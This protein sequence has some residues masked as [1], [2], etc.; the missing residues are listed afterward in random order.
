MRMQALM[1][2][3]MFFFAVCQAVEA[4]GFSAQSANREH[5]SY[6]VSEVAFFA[7]AAK[8]VLDHRFTDTSHPVSDQPGVID[9][10]YVGYPDS[11][12]PPEAFLD[13]GE[14]P[15]AVF[16]PYSQRRI[17][18]SNDNWRIY[19]KRVVSADKVDMWYEQDVPASEYGLWGP[20]MAD[21][22]LAKRQET[23]HVIEWSWILRK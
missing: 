14:H 21:V 2:V 16:L 13:Y 8:A 9:T 15:Q 18:G 5:R 10:F 4:Q 23:W 1:T 6:T 3:L 17:Q 11:A 20:I 22:L 12:D 7:G 19:I